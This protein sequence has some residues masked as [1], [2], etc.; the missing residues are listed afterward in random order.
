MYPAIPPKIVEERL[1]T[2]DSIIKIFSI[3]LS[4]NPIAFK[5]PMSFRAS[6]TAVDVALNT[7]KKAIMTEKDNIR[8]NPFVEDCK[9]R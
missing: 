9:L 2:T 7:A 3:C 4:L 6:I 8:V 5:I 1:R